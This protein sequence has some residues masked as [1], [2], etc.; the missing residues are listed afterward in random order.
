MNASFWFLVLRPHHMICLVTNVE[1][2]GAGEGH[3]AFMKNLE[4]SEKYEELNVRI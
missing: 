1:W 3:A 2:S 4:I